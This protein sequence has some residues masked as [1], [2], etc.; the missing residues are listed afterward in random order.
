MR[1]IRK[2]PHRGWWEPTLQEAR[3]FRTYRS[4]VLLGDSVKTIMYWPGREPYV[5]FLL[6]GRDRPRKIEGNTR[7]FVDARGEL[8]RDR[9]TVRR[10]VRVFHWDTGFRDDMPQI[11]THELL[12]PIEPEECWRAARQ[13]HAKLVKNVEWMLAHPVIDERGSSASRGARASSPGPTASRPGPS[14]R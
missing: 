6:M 12:R 9:K 13:D 7:Y 14:G 10:V 3:M 4:R 11:M 1:D 5:S 8:M 2:V